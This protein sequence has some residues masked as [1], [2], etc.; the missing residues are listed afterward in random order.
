[1]DLKGLMVLLGQ[2]VTQDLKVKPEL[3]VLQAAV[4]R[5]VIKVV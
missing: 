3:R 2:R 4:D 5:L 1:M